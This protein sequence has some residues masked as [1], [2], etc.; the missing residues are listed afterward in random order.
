[1]PQYAFRAKDGMG[2]TV[3]GTVSAGDMTSAAHQIGQMGYT[4]LEVKLVPEP[5][6]PPPVSANDG[7]ETTQAIP[8]L[9][10]LPDTTTRIERSTNPALE[11]TQAIPPQ[12]GM[13]PPATVPVDPLADAARR[14]QMQKELSGLGM[15]PAEIQRFL[16]ADPNSVDPQRPSMPNTVP[17]SPS[18]PKSKTF[19]PDAD[20]M[21]SFAA[22]LAA[23]AAAA[24][25]KAIDTAALGLP[26]FR[27]SSVQETLQAESL[28]REASAFRRREKY[29]EAEAKCREALSLVPKDAAALELLGDLLQGVARTEE[30]L[31]AYRR[32]TEAD[33]KRY[34]AEKKYADLLMRQQNWAAVDP[35]AVDKN[36]FI[37]VLLSALLPGAG[38]FYNGDIAKGAFFILLDVLCVYLLAWSPYGFQGER[39]HGGFNTGLIGSAILTSII[40]LIGVFDANITAR[41]GKGGRRG[42]S[43][44]EV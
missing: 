19:R 23:S 17:P 20:S 40:Y 11:P 25:Q 42:G 44:W 12:P 28:L 27:E 22:G 29:R 14:Q 13:Q 6:S 24:R 32:A 33:P 39:Q 35:E 5:A 43:G 26:E 8:T 4:V 9:P 37:A 16:N 15:S 7:T 2:N 18:A 38:Q 31:A 34:S 36:P 3:G 41:H 1:M 30:A 10:P 21:Q